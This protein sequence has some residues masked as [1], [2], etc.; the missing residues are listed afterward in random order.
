[1]EWIHA[2][3]RMTVEE[4]KAV[5]SDVFIYNAEQVMAL[6]NKLESEW[7]SGEVKQFLLARQKGWY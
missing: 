3:N 4:K 6:G 2:F 5:P 7:A 1:M